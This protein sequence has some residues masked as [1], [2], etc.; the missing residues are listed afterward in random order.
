MFAFEGIALV[1]PLQNA[2]KEPKK[3]VGLLG[4]LNVGMVVV[5]IIYVVI[6]FVG[7]WKYGEATAASL[8]LSLP[9]DQM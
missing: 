3:F 4:V 6:G 5:S 2:M 1:L 8:T 9:V 7:Y